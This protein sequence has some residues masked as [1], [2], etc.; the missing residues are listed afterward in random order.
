MSRQKGTIVECDPFDALGWIELDEG[1]RVRFGATAFTGFTTNPG[2]GRRVDVRGTQPGY[3]GVPKAV[4]VGPLLTLEEENA[5]SA[6]VAAEAARPRTPW[7]TFVREHPRW[8][9]AADTCVPCLRSAPRPTLTEHPLFS[10]WHRE[11]CET[12][13]TVVPLSVPSYLQP[14][15]FEPGAAD[16]FAHGRTAFL[17]APR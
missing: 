4:V 6:R 9:D 12:A 16:C 15:P 1:G 14:E 17:D 3:K 8:S 5:A 10:P 2:V 7:P 11:N 13:P